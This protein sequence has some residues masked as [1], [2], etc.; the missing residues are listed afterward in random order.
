M[1]ADADVANLKEAYAFGSSSL[2]FGV[3]SLSLVGVFLEIFMR[4]CSIITP[5]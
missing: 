4:E 2:Q 1:G 5:K 3:T